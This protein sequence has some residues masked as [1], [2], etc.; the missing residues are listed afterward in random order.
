MSDELKEGLENVEEKETLSPEDLLDQKVHAKVFGVEK[1]VSVKDLLETYQKGEAAAE[2]LRQVSEMEKSHGNAI[3][4]YEDLQKAK[5]GDMDAM[6]RVFVTLGYATNEVDEYLGA[7]QEAYAEAQEGGGE[8]L[9]E[10]KNRTKQAFQPKEPARDPQ[11]EKDMA[12]FFV[13]ARQMGI[14]AR[15]LSQMLGYA[16]QNQGTQ[17]L[18][19]FVRS[20][21]EKDEYFA[22]ILK[23]ENADP[24]ALADLVEA[25]LSRRLTQAGEGVSEY[26]LQQAVQEVRSRLAKLRPSA[27]SDPFLSVGDMGDSGL[28]DY[29]SSKTIKVPSITE[30]EDFDRNFLARMKQIHSQKSLEERRQR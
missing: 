25:S 28:P 15:Q 2:K 14:P 18:K 24:D 4:A 3:K 16:I 21:V 11:L 29:R 19:K 10:G 6:K 17:E 8:N 1:E 30:G 5:L 9:F 7:I 23:E 13:T 20:G 12:E 26:H 27:P 22:K